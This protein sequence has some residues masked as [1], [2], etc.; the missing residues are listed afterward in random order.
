MLERL[1]GWFGPGKMIRIPMGYV[2]PGVLAGLFVLALAYMGGYSRR[3][4]EERQLREMEAKRQLDQL[5]DP[6]A[7]GDA[8]PLATNGGPSIG[9]SGPVRA[10]QRTD[11]LRSPQGG[12]AAPGQGPAE[13][14][15]RL[16]DPR[17]VIVGGEA[18]DPRQLGLNYL[19]AATL[20]P[21]EAEKAAAFLASRGLEVAVVPRDN[22]SSQREV[23]VLR[24]F[25]AGT[26]NGP[27]AL[28]LQERLRELG[29]EYRRE[30]RGPAIFA[31]SWWKK[32]SPRKAQP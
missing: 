5:T 21:D 29:R 13:R 3:G 30:L 16:L 7:T 9:S 1:S 12:G 17:V 27:E 23:V 25:A 26:I 10:P 2:V 15:G 31:D 32:H 19:V 18:D 11:G 6:L 24:G 22:R 28:E 4:A 20:P 14:G 8:T